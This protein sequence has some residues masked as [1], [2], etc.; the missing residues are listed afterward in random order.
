MYIISLVLSIKEVGKAA[1]NVAEA[2]N[3]IK[4]LTGKVIQRQGIFDYRVSNGQDPTSAAN[5]LKYSQIQLQDAKREYGRAK[6]EL[7]QAV[8]DQ[9]Q[10]NKKQQQEI[11]KQ[12]QENNNSNNQ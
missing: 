12:Q 11:K 2:G 6:K 5:D 10:E 3:K 7:Q 1:D 9:D 8:K 4:T